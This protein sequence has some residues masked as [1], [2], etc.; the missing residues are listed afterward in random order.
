[1]PEVEFTKRSP[2]KSVFNLTKVEMTNNPPAKKNKSVTGVLTTT[3]PT[4]TSVLV[5]KF[6][7]RNRG[8]SNSSK[9][10]SNLR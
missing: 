8:E 7:S 3:T 1:M 4:A 6:K 9:S 2:Q 10:Q 5:K